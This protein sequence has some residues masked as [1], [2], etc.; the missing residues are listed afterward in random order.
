[1]AT[2]TVNLNGQTFDLDAEIANDD[3]KLKDALAPYAP[4]IQNATISRTQSGTKWLVTVTKRAGTKG[5]AAPPLSLLRDAPAWVNPALLL[6]WDLHHQETIQPLDV[7]AW[8]ERYPA[9]EEARVTGEQ[10]VQA[11]SAALA[12]LQQSRPLPAPLLIPGV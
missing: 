7:R 8:V 9:I 5:S 11:V 2:V 12:R 6:A 10:A 4:D 3:Q 1:M